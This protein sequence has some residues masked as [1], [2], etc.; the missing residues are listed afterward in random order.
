MEVKVRMSQEIYILKTDKEKLF[1]IID[2]ATGQEIQSNGYL[3]ALEVEINKAR[4]IDREVLS[5][6]FIKMNSKVIMTVDRDE[7]EITLVYPEEADIKNNKISVL[8]PIGTAILGYCVG[9]CIEWKVPGGTV[10]IQ[11]HKIID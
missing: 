10:T 1:E 2:K 7:E 11:I 5:H 4:V 3:K 6:K 9:D 8:A